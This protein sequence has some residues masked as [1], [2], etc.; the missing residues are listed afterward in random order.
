MEVIKGYQS[1]TVKNGIIYGS[2][3]VQPAQLAAS[4]AEPIMIGQMH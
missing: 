2:G 4:R 1:T 3:T